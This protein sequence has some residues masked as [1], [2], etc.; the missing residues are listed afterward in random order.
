MKVNGCKGEIHVTGKRGRPRSAETQ[1]S[2]LTNAYELLLEEGF[3]AVTVEKIAERAGVSKATI[4]KW[5]PNKAFVVMDGFLS[6]ASARLPVPDTGGLMQ[7]VRLHAARVASFMTSPDGKIITDLIGEGQFDSGLAEAYRSRYFAPRRLEA[8]QLLERGRS[9]GELRPDADIDL[10]IDLIYGPI[11]Y[12]LLIFGAQ[13]D[14]A[15]VE[16]LVK[17]AFEGLLAEP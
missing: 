3:A 9:R 16:R 4:Y 1:Q 17:A 6:A 13:P 5:W 7:D 15:Y 11:F 2:I 8:R 12:N 10:A 14:D